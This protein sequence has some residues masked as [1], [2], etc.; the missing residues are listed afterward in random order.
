VGAEGA[1]GVPPHDLQ[2]HP[3]ELPKFFLKYPERTT[4]DKF[5]GKSP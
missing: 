3:T 1:E 4:F 2:P 5:M